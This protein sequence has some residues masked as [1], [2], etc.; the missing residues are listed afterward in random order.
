E[1]RQ[2]QVGIAGGG[3]HVERIGLCARQ[4][5]ELAERLH[6]QRC[7]CRKCNHN[8]RD[9]RDWKQVA[10]RIVRQFF[11]HVWVCRV[12]RSRNEQK[13]V[14]VVRRGEWVEGDGAVAA[15]PVLDPPRLAPARCELFSEQRGGD[16]GPGGGTKRKDE[17]ARALRIGLSRGGSHATG[18]QAD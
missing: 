4:R 2:D 1:G 17:F 14:V 3:R 7:W 6:V 18:D 8:G 5:N 16:V 15:R 10:L 13:R 11:V 9:V 12:G